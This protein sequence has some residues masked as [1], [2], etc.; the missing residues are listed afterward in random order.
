MLNL[1]AGFL[2]QTHT[3]LFLLTTG[4]QQHELTLQITMQEM[5]G[6]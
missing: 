4:Y 3:R 1:E 5:L 6:R 2:I